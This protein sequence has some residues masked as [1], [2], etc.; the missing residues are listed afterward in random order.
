MDIRIEGTAEIVALTEYVHAA[1]SEASR[2]GAYVHSPGR[3]DEHAGAGG[4]GSG[5][6]ADA[7]PDAG[8]VVHMPS[9]I[10]QRVGATPTAIK[11]N[12]LAIAADEDLSSAA[13]GA[14]HVPDHVHPHNIHFL[15]FAATVDG[16]SRLAIES[17]RKVAASHRRYGS[18]R[19]CRRQRYSASCRTGRMR[20][21]ANGTRF[22][23]SPPRRRRTHS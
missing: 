6:A 11:S 19:R 5:Y 21:S 9:H 16:Q 22:F 15:W 14:G 17:A 3:T 7:M 1:Q 8:H 23:R 20:D 13:P 12:Q 4:E 18:G 10:Y 2:R